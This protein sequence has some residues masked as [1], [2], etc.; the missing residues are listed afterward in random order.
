MKL[1][2]RQMCAIIIASMFIL[3]SSAKAGFWVRIY[4]DPAGAHVYGP[5]GADW[6]LTAAA[7][8]VRTAGRV[9]KGSGNCYQ[10]HC[11]STVSQLR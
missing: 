10:G 5:D 3:V 9:W 11:E 4:S 7:P 2:L 6:G 8:P 1:Y